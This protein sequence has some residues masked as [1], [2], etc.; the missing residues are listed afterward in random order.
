MPDNIPTD[1][2]AKRMSEIMRRVVGQVSNEPAIKMGLFITEA[3][4]EKL[5]QRMR[6]WK[7]TR[8]I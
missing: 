2:E 1:V 7:P 6:A 3:D 4:K 8:E 5:R